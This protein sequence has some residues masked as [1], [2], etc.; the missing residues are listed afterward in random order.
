MNGCNNQFK[1]GF[2]TGA[3]LAAIGL[4]SFAMTKRG[5]KC[6]A[7]LQ[8]DVSALLEK[9]KAKMN[10]M[11]DRDQWKFDKLMEQLVAEY[12]EKKEMSQEIK[13]RLI[14]ELKAKWNDFKDGDRKSE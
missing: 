6:T 12:A 5:S 1:R 2:F 4:V 7:D 13:D 8:K 10:D 11:K 3:I 9:A 14:K